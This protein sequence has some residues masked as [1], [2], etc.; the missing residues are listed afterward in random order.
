[1]TNCPN[2]GFLIGSNSYNYCPACAETIRR[3]ELICPGKVYLDSPFTLEIRASGI[4]P[5]E[6]RKVTLGQK[7]ILEQTFILEPGDSKYLEGRLE[8][9]GFYDLIVESLGSSLKL[10]IQVITM[11]S[12][13]FCWQNCQVI[14]EKADTKQQKILVCRDSAHHWIIPTNHTKAWLDLE[15]LSL[16]SDR[17][18]FDLLFE[19]AFF[20]IP[21]KFF[22]FLQKQESQIF[23]LEA[24]SKSGHKFTIPGLDFVFTQSLPEIKLT[25]DDLVNAYP[26]RNAREQVSFKLHYKWKDKQNKRPYDNLKL[27]I[28][29]THIKPGNHE[30]FFNDKQE[31]VQ[32][33]TLNLDNIETGIYSIE[34]VADYQSCGVALRT[35]FDLPYAVKRIEELP[36]EES[37]LVSIDFG[38]SNTCLAFVVGG[39][40]VMFEYGVKEF[41]DL[42]YNATTIKFLHL[43]DSSPDIQIRVENSGDEPLTFAANF[44]PRLER[45]EELFFFDMQKPRNIK[46]LKPS[47]LTKMYLKELLDGAFTKLGYKPGKAMISYPACFSDSA[48]EKLNQVVKDIGLNL[49]HDSSLSEPENIALYFSLLDNSAIQTLLLEQK[50][51]TVCVFDCGGGTTDVSIVK[52]VN[53][54]PFSFEILATWG[55][56]DFSGNYLS[57]LIGAIAD[58]SKPWFPKDFHNLYTAKNEDLEKYFGSLP[59]YETIKRESIIKIPGSY[60]VEIYTIKKEIERIFNKVKS[61]LMF[62]LWQGKILPQT[63][64]D[65]V[66]LAGNSCKLPYFNELALELFDESIVIYEPEL[67]KTA[68]A[69]GALEAYKRRG[70]MRIRGL[71]RSDYEYYFVYGLFGR[72]QVFDALQD[73]REERNYISPLVQPM[74][75]P[76]LSQKLIDNDDTSPIIAFEVPAP[77][78]KNEAAEYK[79]KL[80]FHNKAISY[81]WIECVDGEIREDDLT[82]IYR[83][84]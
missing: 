55:T 35:I 16:E 20:R 75:I 8:Q 62:N 51:A 9:T 17:D 67:G 46:A 3:V 32:G 72:E 74:S 40:P 37:S 77:S 47:Q 82:F 34:I 38:T 78:H 28:R 6:I 24:I 81:A 58:S 1:M 59:S 36:I 42:A 61:K 25:H 54:I 66:I 23:T 18:S 56:E 4:Q 45:D 26:M 31:I 19:Y 80:C 53:D 83:E 52:L 71:R 33:V 15:Y 84:P 39:K 11:G 21:I 76:I 5:V 30:S 64:T 79:F 63:Q 68:V 44:K 48:K 49:E 60:S 69:L 12:L 27:T 43:K 13:S 65:F 10:Q 50:E 70:T 7:T 29:G 2:C 73:A 41:R 22:D 57:Y 14:E